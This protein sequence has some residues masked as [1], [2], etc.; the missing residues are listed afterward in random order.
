[1]DKQIIAYPFYGVLLINKKKNTL[2][3]HATTWIDHYLRENVP[4]N[5]LI[6]TMHILPALSPKCQLHVH[7]WLAC[8]LCSGPS[9]WGKQTSVAF[10][11]V[12]LMGFSAPHFLSFHFAHVLITTKRCSKAVQHCREA[13]LP[14]G[15]KCSKSFLQIK[16]AI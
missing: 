14:N 10:C 4:C 7:R 11:S 2:L 13:V 1:M 5:M 16:M 8:P 3:T 12:A 9:L 15:C 6:K